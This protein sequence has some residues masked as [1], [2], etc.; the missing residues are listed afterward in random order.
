[1]KKTIF[2]SLSILVLMMGTCNIAV[3][4]TGISD[5]FGLQAM[6]A[7]LGED[8]YLTGNIDCSG[9]PNFD[10]IGDDTNPFTGNFDG[11]TFTISNLTINRPTEDYVGLFGYTSSATVENVA[12]KNVDVAGFNNVGGLVG[13]S[14]GSISN[15]TTSGKVSGNGYIGGLAGFNDDNGLISDC[16][17]SGTV[18]GSVGIGGLVGCNHYI[19]SR[20]YASGEV[21][22]GNFVGGLIGYHRGILNDCYATGKV[23]GTVM[24]TGGLAGYSFSTIKRCYATVIVNGAD[25]TGGLVGH[26]ETF[27][28]DSYAS[29]TVTGSGYVGGFIG[30]NNN[31]PIY[32]CH[33]F[34]NQSNNCGIGCPDA[35]VDITQEFD[36]QN[37][38]YTSHSVYNGTD[39]WDFTNIWGIR[40]G[41]VYPYL[42]NPG[43]LPPVFEIATII[44][45]C[46]GLLSIAGFIWHRKKR[47]TM[48]TI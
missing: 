45:V 44:F 39:N 36:Q 20:C 26:S 23:T 43:I 46:I 35:I 31:I 13:L 27:I 5:V 42:G 25:R 28:Y 1:M 18:T 19:V 16:H 48:Q 6:N 29:G 12:M 47:T 22:G 21:E 2:V 15:C 37:F 14:D 9:I 33:W 30:F 41:Q 11:S 24:Y 34:G 17:S 40:E 10:P 4:S 8:Y 32:N 38:F 7:N 3:A